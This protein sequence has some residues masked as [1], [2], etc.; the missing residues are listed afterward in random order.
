MESSIGAR[1]GLQKTTK[2]FEKVMREGGKGS[3][4][5]YANFLGG[6][7]AGSLTR[8]GR[9]HPSSDLFGRP[10]KEPGCVPD[11][12]GPKMMTEFYFPWPVTKPR[13]SLPKPYIVLKM[14][15]AIASQSWVRAVGFI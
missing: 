11:S 13:N 5:R 4:K 6:I 8:F 9:G 1:P 10:R 3:G 2:S 7:L 15:S 12:F 14:P